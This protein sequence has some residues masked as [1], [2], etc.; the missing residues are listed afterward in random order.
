MKKEDLINNLLKAL[1]ESDSMNGEGVYISRREA[2]D[3]L[4]MLAGQEKAKTLY[5]EKSGRKLFYCSDCGMSFWAL[6]REVEE[7]FE[8]YHYHTWQANC[9]KCN[10]QVDQNDRYWR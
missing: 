7:C 2:L 4:E 6:P 5:K 8:K 10:R 1:Q 9:P 3:L